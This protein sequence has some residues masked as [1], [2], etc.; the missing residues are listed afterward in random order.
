MYS[1]DYTLNW[2]YTF[3][4]A[5]TSQYTW[6]PFLISNVGFTN[7]GLT[8]RVL[9]I[10]NNGLKHTVRRPDS[11]TKSVRSAVPICTPIQPVHLIPTTSRPGYPLRSFRDLAWPKEAVYPF[12]W[13]RRTRCRAHTSPSPPTE[14]SIKSPLLLPVRNSET[15]R[16]V[17]KC[18]KAPILW[19]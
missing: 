1:Q 3:P 6:Y 10:H 2:P 8:L 17:H 9:D 5:T 13:S 7:R 12:C 16:G 15:V 18:F 4:F 19:C 14:E 11:L